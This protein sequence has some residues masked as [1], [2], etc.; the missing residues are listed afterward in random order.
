MELADWLALIP[1]VLIVAI[2]AFF[3]V[4]GRREARRLKRLAAR[5]RVAN[6]GVATVI[7]SDV[8]AVSHGDAKNVSHGASMTLEVDTG[9]GKV[10][11]EVRWAIGNLLDIERVRPGCELEVLIDRDDPTLLWPNE[12]WLKETGLAGVL[13]D[14]LR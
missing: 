13:A 10:R 8:R 1:G 14:R 9:A 6:P 12:P 3:L 11:A 5:R 4:V 7:D 2:V